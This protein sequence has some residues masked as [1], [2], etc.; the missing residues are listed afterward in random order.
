LRRKLNILLA[1]DNPVNRVFAQ[2]PLQKHGHTVTSVNNGR[3]ALQLWEQNQSHQFDV[4]LMD[5]QMPEMD[6]L[7][8]S[9]LI[10]EKDL[11]KGAH[12]PIIAVTAHA[13]KGDRERCLSAEMD[14]YI[15]KPINPSELTETVQNA[16]R[17]GTKLSEAHADPNPAG[18]SDTELLARFD[19]DAE[20]LE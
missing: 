7:Q 5:V 3:A 12:I 19:G 17:H 20:L 16:F 15:T 4:I 14:G 18:P 13:M 10:R 6:G 1:E 9:L 8:A 11:T 2:K